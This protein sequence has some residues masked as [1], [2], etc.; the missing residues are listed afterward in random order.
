[1]DEKLKNKW[2]KALRSG[3]YFQAREALCGNADTIE[4][5]DEDEEG[6]VLKLPNGKIVDRDVEGYCC[7]GVLCE[8]APGIEFNGNHYVISQK[9][10]V[11]LFSN[12]DDDFGGEWERDRDG[13]VLITGEEL[14]RS[15]VKHWGLDKKVVLGGQKKNLHSKLIAMNDNGQDFNKIADY[16]E[17]VL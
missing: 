5:W 6:Y 4:E 9:K 13:N 16:I 11:D 10:L 1:M 3:K 17:K 8:I 15:L 2:I 7:L 14:P 12:D